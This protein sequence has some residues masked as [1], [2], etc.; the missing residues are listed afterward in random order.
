MYI[1]QYLIQQKQ[2]QCGSS[3]FFFSEMEYRPFIPFSS[4]LFVLLLL[5]S[6][7]VEISCQDGDPEYS[8]ILTK[9]PDFED[10]R[11]L[12]AR[13]FQVPANLSSHGEVHD[14]PLHFTLDEPSPK[15]LLKCSQ[16]ESYIYNVS[17]SEGL[18]SGSP[19]EHGIHH[20]PTWRR[21]YSDVTTWNISLPTHFTIDGTFFA[22]K[23]Y[24]RPNE[25]CVKS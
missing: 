13:D 3:V 5:C 9:C 24:Y 14:T 4:V 19:A 16:K 11:N 20:S 7:I 2:V 25:Y 12:P 22:E 10:L 17:W 23:H 15:N 8:A 18:M 21:N 1:I 6:I